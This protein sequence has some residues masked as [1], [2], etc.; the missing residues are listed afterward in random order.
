MLSLIRDQ[1]FATLDCMMPSW[2]LITVTYNSA[3]TLRR[4]WGHN[5]PELVEWIVVDNGSTDDSVNVAR[6]LGA[7]VVDLRTNVGFSA[8]NNEGLRIAR[9]KYVGFLNPDVRGNW[10]DLDELARVVDTSGGLVAPQLT[11]EDQAV[12]P[13]GRGAPFLGHK[14]MNRVQGERAQTDYLVVADS[15]QILH[16]FWLMGAAI[17]GA[18]SVVRELGGWNERFFLYYEDK[19]LCIRAWR[20][21]TPV[22]VHG[23]VRWVHGWA[24]ETSKFRLKPWIRE[25]DSLAR[26]YSLY[27]ELLFNRRAVMRKHERA[28]RMSGTVAN[29][30]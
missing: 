13:N 7:T 17:V 19:D 10:A 11:G 27:P 21:G 22:L 9:G 15:E 28:F 18:A 25:L 14:V 24:R 2:S 12:Q 5:R 26:F 29:L 6:E 23:G 20:R 8:A 1:L 30:E 16:A 4:F 3:Q